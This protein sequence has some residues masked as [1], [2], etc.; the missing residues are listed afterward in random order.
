MGHCRTPPQ[1]P[2]SSSLRQVAQV[3]THDLFG[4]CWF[5]IASTTHSLATAVSC[6]VPQVPTTSYAADAASLPRC[7]VCP[8]WELCVIEHL[9][10]ER[11]KY[12]RALL[13]TLS[14][15]LSML[16]M[17]LH[18]LVNNTLE[19]TMVIAGLCCPTR[20]PHVRACGT[21][22]HLSPLD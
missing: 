20:W 8:G 3:C 4:Q 17:P 14:N 21:I 11:K 1:L 13:D 7:V 22:V 18:T 19:R 10:A 2:H 5:H 12:R 15:S 9:G 6:V 16:K